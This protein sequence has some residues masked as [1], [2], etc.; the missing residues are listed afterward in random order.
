M[1]STWDGITGAISDAMVWSQEISEAV[2]KVSRGKREL[3]A[4]I[5]G[6]SGVLWVSRPGNTA[7]VAKRINQIQ[8]GEDCD[9]SARRALAKGF[10]PMASIDRAVWRT[11]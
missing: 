9:A 4:R 8:A 3:A 5:R 6:H 2:T 1:F 11:I 10:F 7:V